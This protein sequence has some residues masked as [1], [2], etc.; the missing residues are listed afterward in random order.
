MFNHWFWRVSFILFS[1]C[2]G[3][4]FFLFEKEWVDFS[5]LENHDSGKPSVI[6]DEDGN[7]FARF[8]L[9]KREPITFDKLPNILI[10]AFIAAEDWSFFNHCGISFKGILRSFLVNLYKG[11]KVQGG[12]TITQQLAKLMFFSMD[13]DYLRKIKDALLAFQIERRF[14]KQQ[15]LELYLNNV[16][17]GQGIYGVEAACKRFWNKS[18][19]YITLEQ[20]ASLAAAVKSARLYSPINAPF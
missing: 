4:F 8:Q 13:K 17:F 15:I 9:D 19:F 18:V 10:K 1:F 14:T 2:L 16:Y 11:R 7:V 3:I 5:V 6:L 20:A 12:S